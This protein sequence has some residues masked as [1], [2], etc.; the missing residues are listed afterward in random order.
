M[1]S[2]L[3]MTDEPDHPQNEHPMVAP[4]NVNVAGVNSGQNRVYSAHTPTSNSAISHSTG[5]GATHRPVTRSSTR[6]NTTRNS[7][8]SQRARDGLVPFI[9]VAT[10]SDQE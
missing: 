2:M 9:E 7:S 3:S 4:Q 8:V 10:D 5:R 6:V 1:F